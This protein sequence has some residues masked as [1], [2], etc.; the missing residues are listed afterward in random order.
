[1]QGSYEFHA[2]AP[3]GSQ[4]ANHG[5]ITVADGGRVALLGPSV[6]NTGTINANRGV[7]VQRLVSFFIDWSPTWTSFLS[8]RAQHWL[9]SSFAPR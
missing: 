5:V 1:M 8:P 4:I 7:V 9:R 2:P 3:D 6:E